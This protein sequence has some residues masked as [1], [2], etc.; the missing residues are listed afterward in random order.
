[1]GAETATERAGTRIWLPVGGAALAVGLVYMAIFAV[2]PLITVFVDDLGLSHAQAGGLMSV[3]VAGLGLGSLV[4]GPLANRFGNVR[5][6]VAGLVLCAAASFSFA[7]TTSFGLFLLCRA[8]VGLA[9]GFIYAPGLTL[10]VR[11]LPP[12]RA[13]VGVGIFL[14]GLAIGG[15]VAFF[16]TRL[17]EDALGWR[18]PF[19]IYGVACAAGSAAVLALAGSASSRR[20]GPAAAGAGALRLLARSRPFV[21]LC[22]GLFV[23]LFVAYGA[24]TW[25]A[26]YLDESAGFS[27][28]EVSL[29]LTLM[30]LAGIPGTLLAGWLADRTGR[31]VGVASAALALTMAMVVFA[32]VGNPSFAAATLVA[33]AAALGINAALIPLYALPPV[34]FEPAV[35]VTGSGVAAAS[36]MAGAIV[37]TYFGGYLI[38]AT[39]GYGP[40]FAV[41]TVA[42]A[43]AVFVLLPAVALSLRGARDRAT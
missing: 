17:L 16:A 28:G 29:T 41:Y 43:A 26:P 8:A 31:P 34:L 42:A 25:I 30:T 18:W 22:T 33:V 10:V 2:P 12:R 7:L 27:T 39:D 1:V 3:A 35:A 40:A 14:C 5:V 32:V 9:G 36:G 20:A 37:S 23:A 6:V 15:T 21:L 19:W 24:F 38:G 4:S 13:N 11:L